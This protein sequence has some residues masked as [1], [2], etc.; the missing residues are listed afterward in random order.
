MPEAL[1]A[2]A[3]WTVEPGRGEIRPALL[4]GTPDGDEVTVRALYSGVSRGTESL[5]FHGL[6]P[7]ELHEVMRCPHQDGDFPGPVKYGYNL[8]GVIEDGPQAGQPVFCLHPHQ[9]RLRVPATD[10][11]P[12]PDGVPERRAVLAGIME[13]AVN[14][15]WD[16][17]PPVGVRA[18]VVGGGTVGC[19]AAFLLAQ[20]PGADVQLVDVNPSRATI[21][22]QLGIPFA[23]PEDATGERDLLVHTSGNAEGLTTALTLAGFEGT[24]IEAS[25]YGRAMVSIPLG[26]AFH[27]RR[28][29]LISSQVGSVAASMRPRRSHRDRLAFALSLLTDA[30]LDALI[31]SE[32]P[33][34]ALPAV[35]KRLSA[36]PSN[37]LCLAVR[38]P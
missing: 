33:F 23:R 9:T 10:L 11:F 7:P 5:V 26:G 38:Y 2:Q 3:F 13:T 1:P 12:L 20:M 25:W 32:T 37:D 29:R 4:G 19:L 18:T 36:A 27:P 34:A 21:A 15:L 22:T 24:I 31:T 28:L 30:R 14:L 16:A 8:V 35:M 6:V 17:L